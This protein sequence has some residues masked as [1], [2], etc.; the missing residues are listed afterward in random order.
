MIYI[1]IFSLGLFLGWGIGWVHR[2][3]REKEVKAYLFK[4][5]SDNVNIKNAVKHN[6]EID[7]VNALIEQARL[8]QQE[9]DAEIAENICHGVFV[10]DASDYELSG[11]IAK[12]IREE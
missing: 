12:A 1:L 7:Y 9:K 11:I 5:W 2:G 10:C 6:N 4:V 8:E 3:Q